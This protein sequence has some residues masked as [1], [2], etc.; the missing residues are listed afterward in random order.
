MM[1]AIERAKT[2][3]PPPGAKGATNSIGFVGFHSAAWAS[4]IKLMS[5]TTAAIP[6]LNTFPLDKKSAFITNLLLVNFCIQN[7][8]E[9]L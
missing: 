1:L 6:T 7:R 5:S 8:V 4:Q 3:L 9:F 2:S